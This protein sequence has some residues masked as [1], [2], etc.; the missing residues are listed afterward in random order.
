M[1]LEVMTL[2]YISSLLLRMLVLIESE[3]LNSIRNRVF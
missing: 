1:K 2:S 3:I